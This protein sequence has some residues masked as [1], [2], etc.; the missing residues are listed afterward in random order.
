[1]TA[2]AL[3]LLRVLETP[4]VGPARAHAI[5][6]W[7]AERQVSLDAVLADDSALEVLLTKKQKQ[8]LEANADAIREVAQQVTDRDAVLVA[9]DDQRYPFALRERLRDRAPVLLSAIGNLSLLAAP[10]VGFC[11]SR[12]ASEKGLSTAQECAAGLA[13]RGVNVVSGYAPGVD[14]MTH[15]TALAEGGT[16]TVVLAEGILNFR[17]KREIEGVW[18]WKRVVVVSEFVP[19]ARWNVGNAMTR[20]R[21]ICALSSAMILIE[22]R[23][24]GGSI[25]AG[26]T[27]LELG[28]PLFAAIYEGMPTSA[29]GN[30]NL[31]KAGAIKLGRS[32][33]TG[34][35]NIEKVL[36][37]IG[38]PK[39]HGTPSRN[40][41][42]P[43]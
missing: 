29:S 37:R 31:L 24:S 9:E 38:H 27:C 21:T 5:L 2:A 22:A 12:E 17:I 34:E 6:A 15:R 35:A 1:M 42:G 40:D 23:E 10:A 7:C 41:E 39:P 32:P 28:I 25:E 13:Q 20:N 33:R 4:G 36:S 19:E 16:T 8:A 11:G 26:R 43:P 30:E 18:D 3:S 14:M